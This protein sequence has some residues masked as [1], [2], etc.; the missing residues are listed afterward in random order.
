VRDILTVPAAVRAPASPAHPSVRGHLVKKH[1]LLLLLA[2]AAAASLAAAPALPYRA[3]RADEP[4]ARAASVARGADYLDSVS[5]RWTKQRDCG[6]CHTNV[7]HLIAAASLKRPRPTEQETLVR[8]F[9]EDR[10]KNWDRGRKGDR[11]RWDTEVVVTAVAL[12]LH[13]AG[14]SGRLHPATKA[15]LDRTWKV[16][17][18]DGAWGWLKC[19]WPPLEHDDYYGAV[20]A[21]V[22][23]GHAPGG[24]A[25]GASAKEGVEKL[26][27][28]LK[29][30][31][32]PN[33]HHRAYLLWA[34]QKLDGLMTR[35]E[36]KKTADALLA[37][38]KP[39]GGWSLPTLGDWE[40]HDGRAN[41]LAAESDGYATGLAV[42][43]LR[44]AGVRADHRAVKG[45]VAWIKSNQRESG[46]WFTRSLNTD[47]A[48]YV[49]HVG[50]AFALMA[51]RECE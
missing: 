42:F 20:F 26:K 38:Q 28:Y 24:Y 16:Q 30:T 41:D 12:A 34:S 47:G 40:G 1:Y 4:K 37:L 7:P 5:A 9:F 46:R 49:T 32:A 2:A 15:A 13:D 39:D 6:S 11:P 45:G 36:Q 27:G 17:R 25:K 31:P 44:R 50:T 22:G 51:L 29:K 18:K 21:A 43:V 35:E 3:S 8:T 10:V 23:V 14:T 48:H 19:Q 33:L